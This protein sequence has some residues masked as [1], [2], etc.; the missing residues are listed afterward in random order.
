MN[1]TGL[2]YPASV[3]GR[4]AIA[5]GGGAGRGVAHVGVIKCLEA[6][7][8]RPDLIVGTSIGALIGSVWACGWGFEHINGWAREVLQSEELRDLGLEIFAEKNDPSLRRLSVSLKE[9]LVFARMGIKPFITKRETLRKLIDRFVPDRNVEELPRQY[10]CTTL[11]IV[12]GTVHLIRTGPLREAVM[13]SISIAGIFPPFEEG[14]AV[15]LDAG[16]VCNVPVDACREMGARVVVAVNLR[17]V[18]SRYLGARTALATMLRADEIACF[19]LNREES[20]R[21][22]VVI[23]PQVESIH[24]ADFSQ[25]DLGIQLGETATRGRLGELRHHLTPR[26]LRP[27]RR[28]VEWTRGRRAAAPASAS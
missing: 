24:W 16:P 11:D 20:L 3:K 12:G 15:F 22:D 1:A 6:E 17:G 25:L 19:R 26:A 23:E 9:R 7:G 13:R 5:L 14:A 21:A 8:I 27:F 28:L 18:L 4:L 2:R 10:A